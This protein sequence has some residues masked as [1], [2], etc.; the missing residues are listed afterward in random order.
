MR[1]GNVKKI[2]GKRVG[3]VLAGVAALSLL[4]MPQTGAS[5]YIGDG[6]ILEINVFLN[7]EA[8]R[9]L[10]GFG[11]PILSV[12]ITQNVTLIPAGVGIITAELDFLFGPTTDPST[13]RANLFDRPKGKGSSQNP[14]DNLNT[15]NLSPQGVTVVDI[16]LLSGRTTVKAQ[17]R[18]E[19]EQG[20]PA[21]DKDNLTFAC[22]VGQNEQ[23]PIADAG[24][25]QVIQASTMASLDGTGS[26]DPNSDPL[27]FQWEQVSGLPVTLSDDTSRTPTFIAPVVPEGMTIVL[28]FDLSVTD[29]IWQSF[30]DR[31][32]V[33]VVGG[34]QPPTCVV[35]PDQ[36]VFTGD[37]VT[38]DGT[39]SFDNQGIPFVCEWTQESGTTVELF[40]RADDPCL[41]DFQAPVADTYGFKLTVTNQLDLSCID[42]MTVVAA[43]SNNQPMA[44][45]GP[46]QQVFE[47]ELVRL[48]CTGSIDPDMDPLT[49][50]W[51]QL[52]GP[53]VPI[54]DPTSPIINFIAP[55][56]FGSPT[57]VIPDLFLPFLCTVSDGELDDTDDV[58]VTVVATTA[59]TGASLMP[60]GE[61]TRMTR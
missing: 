39:G 43:D 31:V 16:P 20:G 11:D 8:I 44:N 30:A 27:T 28:E 58:V 25:D 26:S 10:D 34:S 6:Q 2:F 36:M 51:E 22:C 37:I 9:V 54:P 42:S 18:G 12:P 14:T 55:P 56:I 19:K 7:P 24:P 61:V 46:N 17:I 50:L 48:D 23:P 32:G 5:D 33:F 4:V 13:F 57:A 47:G 41:A 29:G 45:A 60:A 49:F 35:G 15:I 53:L 40:P 52:S 3:S 21:V 1:P 38:L 59:T